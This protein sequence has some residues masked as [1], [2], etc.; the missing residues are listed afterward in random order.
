LTSK[1]KK[2]KKKA[3]NQKQNEPKYIL[4]EVHTSNK[5]AIIGTLPSRFSDKDNNFTK[6]L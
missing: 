6:A 2:K 1:T 3:I 5:M 4:V